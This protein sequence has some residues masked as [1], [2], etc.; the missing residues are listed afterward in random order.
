LGYRV[1]KKLVCTQGK[2]SVI[3][4]PQGQLKG[5]AFCK[6][7]FPGYFA[8]GEGNTACGACPAVKYQDQV[9]SSMCKLCQPGKFGPAI[10]TEICQ[11]C[12]PGNYTDRLGMSTCMMCPHGSKCVKN[13]RGDF[14]G[15]T[16]ID[17]WYAF[18][19]P[20]SGIRMI[21]CLHGKGG[22]ACL[23]GG[24]CHS[25]GGNPTMEGM[26]CGRCVKGY[27]RHSVSGLCDECP[28]VAVT[29][30]LCLLNV[31]VI[32][33][34]SGAIYYMVLLTD[35]TR[36]KNISAVILK[37]FLNYLG[38]SSVVWEATNFRFPIE[39]GSTVAE[40]T[41]LV[42]VMF[43]SESPPF[44]R[45]AAECFAQYFTD[46]YKFH[47]ILGLIW[48]PLWVVFLSVLF[49]IVWLY[50]K[51]SGKKQMRRSRLQTLL[52]VN[53]FVIHPRNT[54][55]LLTVF[56][57]GDFDKPRLL[58]DTSIDCQSDSHRSW[59]I[60]G[61]VGY[62]IYSLGIPLGVFLL[63]QHYRS[64]DK[65]FR[66]KTINTL[67]F[68]YSGFE[69]QYYYFEAIFMCRKVLYQIVILYP[70]L[71]GATK[72]QDQTIMCLSMLVLAVIFLSIHMTC[73][74]YDNRSYFTLDRIEAAM[75]WAILITLLVQA[76]VYISNEAYAFNP[77]ENA[78]AEW[79]RDVRDG[80]AVVIVFLF[81]ARFLW[82]VVFL[83]ARPLF[84]A[85]TRWH[86]LDHGNVEV[87]EQGL[88]IYDTDSKG[89]KLFTT[90]F[91]EITSLLCDTQK[92]IKYSELMGSL[93]YMCVNCAYYQK[94]DQIDKGLEGDDFTRWTLG[95]SRQWDN[96]QEIWRRAV[97]AVNKTMIDQVRES[98]ATAQGIASNVLSG[99]TVHDR[100]RD[101]KKRDRKR[102]H[103]MLEKMK[104]FNEDTV[105]QLVGDRFSIEELHMSMVRLIKE[106]GRP[107]AESQ[108]KNVFDYGR[109]VCDEEDGDEDHV[110]DG[111]PHIRLDQE[112][113][114]ELR[115][116]KAQLASLKEET[117]KV[118]L[119]NKQI[120]I[121]H[122]SK[123]ESLA[124]EIQ[125]AR[126]WKNI[127]SSQERFHDSFHD[128]NSHHGSAAPTGTSD[129]NYDARSGRS[130]LPR[131][132]V[133]V[134][135][136]DREEALD[137]EVMQDTLYHLRN[138]LEAKNS[139]IREQAEELKAAMD[140]MPR[141]E[142]QYRSLHPSDE[143]LRPAGV[144]DEN[145]PVSAMMSIP[146]ETTSSE[147]HAPKKQL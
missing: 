141:L 41:S 123:R 67:G 119:A 77:A 111:L 82:Q 75:L 64:A 145:L 61:M 81:H 89:M 16:N 101:N 58:M 9:S 52:V 38:M 20:A 37:Q 129:R 74:P 122:E 117:K 69:P 55:L 97:I 4:G 121:Q 19:H 95:E 88:T 39:L 140:S 46:P 147:R 86:V 93:K 56:R 134:A 30:F 29:C 138:E 49:S 114:T 127:E 72:E 73:E 128:D 136:D 48:V 50:Q 22:S 34:V 17:G 76:W 144:G 54:E 120:L 143:N 13:S 99:D 133:S 36:P 132:S 18:N 15:Y 80:I 45:H 68:L 142:A 98:A 23:Q 32:V 70:A 26:F 51:R 130:E 104:H 3:F 1:C 62:V 100:D 24:T 137:P 63:L 112:L 124:R 53:L 11:S 118:E 6:G 94:K 87:T 92:E 59:Q 135:A 107:D 110:E 126:H 57:C 96:F 106:I 35:L 44:A 31:V 27:G 60:K 40:A 2:H 79:N 146:E 102:A 116:Y 21:P 84:L 83:M 105:S 108:K 71:A 25:V 8:V 5:G 12:P 65:L 131:T 91:Q 103:A 10:G 47:V 109:S 113:E 125:S 139:Q 78:D 14:D 42:R 28:D 115:V 66:K 7:C 85:I 90:M 33:L 43:G